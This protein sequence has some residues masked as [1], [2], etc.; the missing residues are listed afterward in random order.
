MC[1]S[2]STKVRD[3]KPAMLLASN[4][5]FP[6]RPLGGPGVEVAVDMCVKWHLDASQS[7]CWRWR[8]VEGDCGLA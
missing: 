2:K 5:F 7:H 8:Y 6:S 3:P 1:V 4:R